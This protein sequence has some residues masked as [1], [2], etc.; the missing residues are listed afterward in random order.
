MLSVIMPYRHAK[1]NPGCEHEDLAD[2]YITK[3]RNGKTGWLPLRFIEKSMQFVQWDGPLVVELEKR[4]RAVVGGSR[5]R[6]D[7]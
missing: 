2:I 1:D 6:F 7:D 5:S 3:Q 4:K